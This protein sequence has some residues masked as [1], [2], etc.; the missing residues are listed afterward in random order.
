ML[1]STETLCIPA[2]TAALPLL[3]LHHLHATHGMEIINLK[4]LPSS[5]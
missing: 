3:A 1:L 4:F 2:P 5:A